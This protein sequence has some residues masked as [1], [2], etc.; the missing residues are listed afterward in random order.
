MSDKKLMKLKREELLEMLIEQSKRVKELK[1]KLEEAEEKLSSREIM[2]NQSGSI[3]EAALQLNGVFEAAESAC[4]QYTENIENLSA[5]QKEICEQME[6]ECLKKT[7]SLTEE[8]YRKC[9]A[10]EISTRN[11]CQDMLDTAKIE[12]QKYWDEISARLEKI[13]TANSELREFMP[14]DSGSFT[15]GTSHEDE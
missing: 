2:I 13:Y 14:V 5:R 12:S 3:A 10:M 11:K 15:E 7:Q 4:R 1:E 9:V 8:T 6:A